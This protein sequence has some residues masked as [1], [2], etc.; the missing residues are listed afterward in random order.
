M[1][2]TD[3]T[4]RA[5]LGA[6]AG[7]LAAPALAQ[8]SWPDRPVRIVVPYPPGA[9]ND[10]LARLVA[11]RFQDAF[12][13]PGVVENRPGA[14]GSV[15]TAAVARS[16]PDGYTLLVV[17][18]ATMGMNPFIYANA[19][20]DPAR[21]LTPL[22]VGARLA[23]V[24]VV[25]PAVLPVSTVAELVERAKAQPGRINYA[26]S[27]SGSSPHL[28][29]E[30]LKARAGIDIAHVPYRGSA[31]AVTDLLGGNVPVMFD[32]IPNVLQHIQSGRLR[33]LAVTG[34]DRDPALPDVP[35]LH[36]AGITGYEMYVWFGFVAPATLPAPLQRRLSEMIIRTVSA[37]DVAERIRRAGAEPW[38]QNPAEMSA[39]IRAELE[40]WG[41]V[42]R[43]A[44]IRAD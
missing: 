18:A 7:L 9:F 8:G 39:L 41:P 36:Q 43:A 29:A 31:P 5:L 20:Y 16:A 10:Q 4:R 14:G 28:A 12:G 11:E 37:P 35:T 40:K 38:A 34:R 1:R 42:I 19:G 6:T 24:L 33:A 15:G 26:S 3:V 27:G 13:Q 17:N 2:N 23:N 25:N 22:A 21:D 44:G 32:N 30:L